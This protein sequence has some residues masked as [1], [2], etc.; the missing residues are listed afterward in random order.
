[1]LANVSFWALMNPIAVSVA[2]IAMLIKCVQK[3]IVTI[4]PWEGPWLFS[5]AVGDAPSVPVLIVRS[6]EM[7]VLS[8]LSAAIVE[9]DSNV[10]IY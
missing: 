2:S 1:M 9:L 8:E 10:L 6:V 3:E 7:F 4:F 5:I